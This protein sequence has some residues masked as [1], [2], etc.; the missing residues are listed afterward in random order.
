MPIIEREDDV[1]LGILEDKTRQR[2]VS[3]LSQ[4]QEELST[5]KLDLA[6]EF[7]IDLQLND[8]LDCEL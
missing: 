2:Q 1:R 6:K 8:R 4:L 5:E 7:N 3:K